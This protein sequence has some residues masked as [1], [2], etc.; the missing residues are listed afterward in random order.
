MSGILLEL[1]DFTMKEAE[2]EK[3]KRKTQ[4]GIYTIFF[5]RYIFLFWIPTAPQLTDLRAL[6]WE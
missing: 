3:T 4:K 6:G 5:L 1:R 2:V